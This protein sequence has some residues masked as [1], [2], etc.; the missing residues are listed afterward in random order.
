VA[1]LINIPV[2]A[3]LFF[4][5]ILLG[6]VAIY[7]TYAAVKSS[8]TYELKKRL[9]TLAVE[10]GAELPPD[11]R[12]EILVEMTPI[13]KVLYKFKLIRKLH[14]LLEKAGFK[15]DVKIFLLI[16]LLTAAVCFII[17]ALLQRGILPSIILVI[18]GIAIIFIYL[19]FKK[20][21]RVLK[22]SDQFANALDMMSRSLKAGHSLAAAIQMIGTEMSEPVAGVFKAVYEEQT[23]GLSM[24]D[25]LSNMIKRMDTPDV[26]FFVTAVSVY[27]EIGGNLSEILERLA[28]TIR[29]RIKIRR[30]VRVYTAQARLS[31]YILAALP[32]VVFGLFYFFIAPDYVMELFKVKIGIIF[33]AA[34]V[35]LQII[36]FFVI[37]R[38]INIR[39]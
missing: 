7:M 25:A 13:D 15:M 22:F 20:K 4:I 16:C 33:V 19:H 30:Q 2:I 39:I 17:G 12:L 29:E 34:A 8:P 14:N 11:M 24:H 28:H 23:Y 35:V 18:F 1:E 36:G 5:A 27:R 6:L 3:G 10:A 31:G 9:R 26:R 21:Q 32:L 37:R 38:I